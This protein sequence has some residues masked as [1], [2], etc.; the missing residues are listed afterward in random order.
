MMKMGKEDRGE[1]EREN[2]G[3]EE[4]NRTE[5]EVNTSLAFVKYQDT[6][7]QEMIHFCLNFLCSFLI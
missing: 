1:A 7:V 3:N 5:N 4:G 6:S 2:E